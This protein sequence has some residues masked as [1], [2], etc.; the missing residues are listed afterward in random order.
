MAVD[1]F[2]LNP[3]ATCDDHWTPPG[4]CSRRAARIPDDRVL[5]GILVFIVRAINFA[6]DIAVSVSRMRRFARWVAG[7]DAIVEVP[8]DPK[9]LPPA[10]QRALAEAERRRLFSS[11]ASGK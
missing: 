2:R 1:A 5:W 11:F 8:P 3:I 10:A 9:V 6:L 7:S 4:Q